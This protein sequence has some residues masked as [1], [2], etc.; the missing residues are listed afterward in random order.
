MS[1]GPVP[2]LTWYGVAKKKLDPIPRGILRVLGC[3]PLETCR[4][5]LAAAGMSPKIRGIEGIS[6]AD[7]CDIE[8]RS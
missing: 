6:E 3:L 7:F 8:Y 1:F 2:K 4:N 5:P